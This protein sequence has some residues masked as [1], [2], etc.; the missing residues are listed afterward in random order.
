MLSQF[1]HHAKFY[2]KP[3]EAYCPICIPLGRLVIND[4]NVAYFWSRETVKNREF[5]S[6]LDSQIE[7]AIV[8]STY[9]QNKIIIKELPNW[10]DTKEELENYLYK[11]LN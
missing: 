11:Y 4:S 2:G 8:D 5:Y 10:I 9:D 7:F 3:S 1:I 6:N